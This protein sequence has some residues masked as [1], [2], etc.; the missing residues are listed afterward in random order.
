MEGSGQ[1]V[2]GEFEA[3]SRSSH[4]QRSEQACGAGELGGGDGILPSPE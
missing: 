1:L 3:K 4:I 2:A